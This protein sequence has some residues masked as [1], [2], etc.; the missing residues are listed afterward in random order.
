MEF[1]YLKAA[2]VQEGCLLSV[3]KSPKVL[4]NHLTSLGRTKT[5]SSK[6]L[7]SSFEPW[8]PALV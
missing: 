3:T 6:E 8:N 2:K 5:E 4:G 1:T 7:S